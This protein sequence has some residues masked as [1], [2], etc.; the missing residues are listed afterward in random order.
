M[1]E[2]LRRLRAQPRAGVGLAA[3]LVAA[4]PP[5]PTH[6]EG[7]E[8]QARL[9]VE[10]VVALPVVG[11]KSP[12]RVLYEVVCGSRLLGRL[13]RVDVIS[14]DTCRGVGAIWLSG[15]S[16]ISTVRRTTTERPDR[17]VQRTRILGVLCKDVQMLL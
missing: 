15:Y 5:K 16:S 10:V 11:V 17:S 12:H 7:D 2:L 9:G 6:H 3:A 4:A 14:L 13:N 1:V 8:A